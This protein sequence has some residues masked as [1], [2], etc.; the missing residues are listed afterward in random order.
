MALPKRLVLSSAQY[1]HPPGFPRRKGLFHRRSSLTPSAPGKGL[2]AGGAEIDGV[3]ERIE[4]RAKRFPVRLSFRKKA[5]HPTP[6]LGRS[7][8]PPFAGND[9]AM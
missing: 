9:I 8:V 5:N 6:K 1:S 2:R 7:V 4:L 3:E